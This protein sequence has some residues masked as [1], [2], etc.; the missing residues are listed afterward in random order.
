[1][2]SDIPIFMYKKMKN[3]MKTVFMQA[4]ELSLQ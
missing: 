3:C 4:F 2:F 1:M